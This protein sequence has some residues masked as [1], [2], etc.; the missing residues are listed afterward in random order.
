MALRGGTLKFHMSLEKKMNPMQNKY[1]MWIFGLRV[2]FF[3]QVVL[4][5]VQS[6]P[7]PK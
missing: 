7:I 3:S 5:L 1:S 6:N 2:D 4:P